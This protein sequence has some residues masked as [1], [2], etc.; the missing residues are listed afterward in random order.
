MSSLRK[1]AMLATLPLL[2]ATS[3]C[4]RMTVYSPLEQPDI[5][6]NKYFIDFDDHAKWHHATVW[7]IVDL[8]STDVAALCPNG[9]ASVH[10]RQTF[11][12]GLATTVAFNG[13]AYAPQTVR[14]ICTDDVADAAPAA[15]GAAAE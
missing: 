2:L 5:T 3:G 1:V 4:F 15:E 11:L 9:Y 13:L 8:G 12:N 14:A 6:P 10:M 7:G